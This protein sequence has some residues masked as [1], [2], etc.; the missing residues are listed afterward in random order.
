MKRLSLARVL[1]L[2]AMYGV[3]LLGVLWLTGCAGAPRLPEQVLVPTPIPCPA[4]SDVPEAPPRFLT[5]DAT[6]PGAAVKA[7]AANRARWIGYGDA[8]RTKLESCK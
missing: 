5:L 3:M 6:Q 7:Y 4:A 1:I 2:V 8:L